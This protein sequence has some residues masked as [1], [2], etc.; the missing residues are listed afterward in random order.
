MT[1]RLK[2]LSGMSRRRTL[3]YPA[4]ASTFP[5]LAPDPAPKAPLQQST[6]SRHFSLQF[7]WIL[8]PRPFPR[9]SFI[10]HLDPSLAFLGGAVDAASLDVRSQWPKAS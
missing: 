2:I 8:H 3:R 5:L 4:R 9:R 10:L 6:I 7:T 1:P